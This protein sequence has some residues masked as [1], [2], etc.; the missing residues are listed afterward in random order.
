MIK[1]AIFLLPFTLIISTLNNLTVVDGVSDAVD[2]AISVFVNSI[3]VWL[4]VIIAYAITFSTPEH[5]TALGLH[6][7]LSTICLVPMINYL[8]RKLYKATGNVWLGAIFVALFLG[9]RLAGYISH[10]FMFW[11]Y[12][13][14]VARF[15]GF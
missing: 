4:F 1:Y 12:D 6:T 11:D 10:R 14:V 13:S 3:G 5:M 8:Y 7:M 15:F 9:W 2:T